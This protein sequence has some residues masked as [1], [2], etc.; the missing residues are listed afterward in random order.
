MSELKTF[1]VNLAAYYRSCGPTKRQREKVKAIVARWKAKQVDTL[2][3]LEL[4]TDAIIGGVNR[5]PRTEQFGTEKTGD[6]AYHGSRPLI[7]LRSNW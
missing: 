1:A 2:R 6:A 5:L 4:L 3:A 7:G